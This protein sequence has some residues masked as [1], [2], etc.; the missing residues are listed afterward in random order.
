MDSE[1]VDNKFEHSVT[2]CRFAS[3]T[4]HLASFKSASADSLESEHQAEPRFKHLA[5][6]G[7]R[8]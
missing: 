5:M 2:D 3:S 7:G 4:L 1:G 6:R 8:T